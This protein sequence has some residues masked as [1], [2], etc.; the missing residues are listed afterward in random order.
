MGSGNS[1]LVL[2]KNAGMV[3]DGSVSA[4]R[5]V[6][7]VVN[8]NAKLSIGDGTYFAGDDKI[9]AMKEIRIGKKCAISWGVTIIDTDFHNHY[10]DGIINDATKPVIVEDNVWIGCNVTVLKGV[11]IGNG[12]II[13]AGSVVTKDVSPKSLVG[14]NPARLIKTNIDWDYEQI[15]HQTNSEI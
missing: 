12:A 2:R 15:V 5:G 6:R 4:G 11:R 7:I 14:G 13:A 1:V 8:N 10:S 9:Y 3:I